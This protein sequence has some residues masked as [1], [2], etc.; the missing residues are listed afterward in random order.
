MTNKMTMKKLTGSK[1]M[2]IVRLYLS[3]GHS[4]CLR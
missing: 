2:R 1:E 4:T 3:A